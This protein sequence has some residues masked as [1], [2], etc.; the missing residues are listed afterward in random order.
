MNLSWVFA[1]ET[2]LPAGLSVEKVAAATAELGDSRLSAADGLLGRDNARAIAKKAGAYQLEDELARRLELEGLELGENGEF[3]ALSPRDWGLYPEA[4]T[5]S[6]FVARMK[7]S[8]G[9]IRGLLMS[10]SQREAFLQFLSRNRV[11]PKGE[12]EA[13]A[14]LARHFFFSEPLN[15]VVRY[16]APRFAHS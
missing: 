15:V 6:S 13:I 3:P 8:H 16:T 1:S 7:R 4:E 5:W 11:D 2:P 12:P 14:D 9:E 10:P